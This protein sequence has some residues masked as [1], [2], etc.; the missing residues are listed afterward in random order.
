M[1]GQTSYFLEQFFL[2]GEEKDLTWVFLGKEQHF[3][4]FGGNSTLTHHYT[5]ECYM[6]VHTAATEFGSFLHLSPHL[7]WTSTASPSLPSGRPRTASWR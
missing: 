7:G 1:N 5:Y 6:R 4:Q 2:K 3:H